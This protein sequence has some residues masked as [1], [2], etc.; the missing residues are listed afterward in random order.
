MFDACASACRHGGSSI[1]ILQCV[2]VCS[3]Q[4]ETVAPVA[5]KSMRITVGPAQSTC[6]NMYNQQTSCLLVRPEGQFGRTLMPEGIQGFD[7]DAGFTYEL[8]VLVTNDGMYHYLNTISKSID[9]SVCNSYFD[10]CNT[11]TITDGKIAACTRKYC[12]TPVE[13][14]C[15]DLI[16]Q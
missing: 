15:L 13:P 10:G 7:R 2:P 3:M 8:E 11:C 16:T 6:Y 4:T 9:L 5:E 14:R 12:E 1:C